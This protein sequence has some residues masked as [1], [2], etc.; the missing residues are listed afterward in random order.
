MNSL[1][2]QKIIYRLQMIQTSRD[3]SLSIFLLLELYGIHHALNRNGTYAG[4]KR[5][6]L[7]FDENILTDKSQHKKNSGTNKSTLLF[8]FHSK[9]KEGSVILSNTRDNVQIE[10]AYFGR[11]L[12]IF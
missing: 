7:S 2:F 11:V 10:G 8:F 9:P 3:P 5:N 12:S 4:G 1:H 6:P